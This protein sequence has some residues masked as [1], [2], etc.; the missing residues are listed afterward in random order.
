[1]KKTLCLLFV[2][3]LLPAL[4]LALPPNPTQ[5]APPARPE[6]HGMPL[7][8]PRLRAVRRT[9][10]NT[11]ECF[12][13][14]VVVRGGREFL[15][16][17]DRDGVLY[18]DISAA[19]S[20]SLRE[21]LEQALQNTRVR[22]HARAADLVPWEPVPPG[23]LVSLV[24]VGSARRSAK[25]A[26]TRQILAVRISGTDATLGW[27]SA[28]VSNALFGTNGRNVTI[29]ANMN[30]CS[31]GV[32]NF[33]EYTGTGV[34]N[35]VLDVDVNM[36]IVGTSLA[37]VIAEAKTRTAAALNVSL[38]TIDH[39]MWAVPQGAI[40]GSSS[41]WA[42]YA[43]LNGN[44]VTLRNEDIMQISVQMHETGHN[45]GFD[46]S[47]RLNAD[48]SL[49]EYGDRSCVM[50]ISYNNQQV[51][52]KCFGPSKIA[53]MGWFTECTETVAAWDAPRRRA[54]VGVSDYV[55]GVCNASAEA[56]LVVVDTGMTDDVFVSYNTATGWNAGVEGGTANANDGAWKVIVVK[57]MCVCVCVCMG[58]SH[59]LCNRTAP[60]CS[61]RSAWP[62]SPR[63]TRSHT[64]TQRACRSS[65]S[66]A[67]TA[68]ARRSSRRGPSR[69]PTCARTPSSPTSARAAR[70]TATAT[71]RAPT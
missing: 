6:L 9:D 64:A 27:T 37:T 21:T 40:K 23:T 47:A 3:A 33:T 5:P 17:P 52:V 22:V 66:T 56:V 30:G 7:A 25:N 67:R 11:F 36:T 71:R 65:S 20:G 53:K 62:C 31:K 41:S 29:K 48:G 70:T 59:G 35:G 12:V 1:M 68:A 32:L 45:L 57:V 4:L 44:E 13:S 54:L 19:V 60:R 2:A 38:S 26:G 15:C 46:H 18:Y 34:V 50:G 58:V 55:P 49:S 10:S 51:P 28:A 61:G 24:A 16:V 8:A 39:I 43:T 14:V 42:A 63:A 69:C